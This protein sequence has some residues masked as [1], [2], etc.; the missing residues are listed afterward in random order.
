MYKIDIKLKCRNTIAAT[1]TV[2]TNIS[3]STFQFYVHFL[4]LYIF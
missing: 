3:V 4:Q 1:N 2:S